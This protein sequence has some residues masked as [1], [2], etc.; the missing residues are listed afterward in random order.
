MYS[1]ECLSS[2]RPKM[3]FLLSRSAGIDVLDSSHLYGK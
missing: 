1:E 3:A 2:A